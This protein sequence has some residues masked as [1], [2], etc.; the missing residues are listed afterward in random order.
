M[1]EMK[2]GKGRWR[3]DNGGGRRDAEAKRGKSKNRR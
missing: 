2:K 3:K 1:N